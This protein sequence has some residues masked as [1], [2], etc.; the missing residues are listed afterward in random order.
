MHSVY[1]NMFSTA[2][3][4]ECCSKGPT[5]L[6]WHMHCGLSRPHRSVCSLRQPPL[7]Y[8]SVC[9]TTHKITTIS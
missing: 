5:S 1:G 3:A 4:L 7:S 8:R 9:T 6:D 2:I